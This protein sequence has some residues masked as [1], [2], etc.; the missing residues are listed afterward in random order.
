MIIFGV[1][2]VSGVERRLA[3]DPSNQGIALGIYEHN[4]NERRDGIVVEQTELMG[5]IMG[6]P[7]GGTTISGVSAEA[8]S[9]ELHIEVRRNEVLLQTRGEKEWD[10]AVG[11][12]DF[13]DALEGVV[14]P[15]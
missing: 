4:S 6:R 12:D 3:V 8:G 10:I 2:Q 13:Q 14:A 11:L 9:S 1:S 15:A 7:V 5:A